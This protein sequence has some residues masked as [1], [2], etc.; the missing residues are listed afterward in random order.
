MKIYML[1]DMEGVSG[2]RRMTQVQ[3]DSP[4]YA[5]GRQLMMADINAAVDGAFLGGATEV[6][7]CDTHASGGQVRVGEMDERAE[8][9]IPGAGRM[10]PALDESFAGVV[11]LGHH[12]RAGTLNG[13]LDHTMSSKQWFEYRINDQVVGEIGIEAA[14]AG[15]YDVPVL[16]VSG[17]AA[18]AAEAQALLGNVTCVVV[19][20]GIGR[21]LARCL[22]LPKAHAILRDGVADAVRRAGERKPFKPALPATLQ[23][24]LYRSD[25]AEPYARRAGVE[26]VDA[27]TVRKEIASLLDVKRW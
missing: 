14:W 13:F 9:E 15:H 6:V 7:V 25:M 26:R 3:A 2:I 22:S 19:K 21:N 4:D 23:L 20:W 10:M 17:D 16:L 27:R 12:A 18:T 24:T 8:Y 5:E 1:C 11:L